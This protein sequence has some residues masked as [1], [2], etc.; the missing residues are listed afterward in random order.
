M[1]SKL[2]VGLMSGTSL[3]GVDAV[4]ASLDGGN[5]CQISHRYFLP[6]PQAL[7]SELL[8]WQETMQFEPACL[9]SNKLA[10]IY[11]QAVKQLLASADLQPAQI[12]AVG[13]HGQTVYHRPEL[14]FS[15]QLGNAALLTELI[16]IDVVADFRSRDIA[17]GGQGAPLVPAFHRA[18]FADAS[19]HRVIVNIGGIANLTDLAP[20]GKTIGFD[21]G[22]GN[23]LMDSWIQS[24]LGRPYDESGLWAAGGEVIDE[25]LQSMLAHAFF[26][27]QPPKS[28][29]RELFSASWLAQFM[30]ANYKAADVQR[31]LLELTARTISMAIRQYCQGA[32]E[33]YLC[34]GGAHNRLLYERLQQLS[35]PVKIGLSDE[36][37]I[38]AD[39]VEAAAF[40]W[41]ARQT[42]HHAA[43]NLP[44]V[45]GAA[46]PRILGAIYQH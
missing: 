26:T 21:T 31:T 8:A 15:V 37:G 2:Y 9:L 34:G 11:A 16:R 28:T 36:L 4:V 25:M 29:G 5:S 1:A 40:A 22:P 24:Q 46:G 14:G 44:E 39:W 17:A 45:T 7:R 12:R 20:T 43:S 32:D 13:C 42:V 38:A 35:A 23:M 6:Y 30:Q 41:L 33:I 19:R 3:D 10:R 18:L 27:E